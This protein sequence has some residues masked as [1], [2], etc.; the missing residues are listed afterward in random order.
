M[1]RIG[2]KPLMIPTGVTID[3]HGT[4]IVVT[5]T[6]GSLTLPFSP[7]FVLTTENQMAL[8][9]PKSGELNEL[10][11][12]HGLYRSLLC[13]AIEGVSKG[14]ERKLEINGVGFR[15]QMNGKMLVLNLG[16]SHPVEYTPPSTVT[17]TVDKNIILVKGFD[18]ETVGEVASLIRRYKKPEPYKGKGIK[19]D[20]E[21]IQRKAGKTA[22]K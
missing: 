3:N 13:N 10:S 8:I 4:R 11:P 21:I 16:F 12:Q 17:V 22:G 19:Y 9:L 7:D 2:K 20:D 15:A 5:G 6:L 18:K 1:S 14:H